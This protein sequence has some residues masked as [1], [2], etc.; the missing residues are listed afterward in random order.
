VSR[1]TTVD[2]RAFEPQPRLQLL[3]AS[4]PTGPS[5]VEDIATGDVYCFDHME[6]DTDTLA[7]EYERDTARGPGVDPPRSY[8][9]K[10]NP[11][12]DPINVWRPFAYLFVGN[13]I[14]LLYQHTP[15]LPAD[16]PEARRSGRLW[17]GERGASKSSVLADQ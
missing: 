13:W 15:Y 14:Q 5:L 11:Y 1:Y 10:K 3:A 12:R 6:Y 17:A 4:R 7:R 8:F 2:A 9:A 16:I